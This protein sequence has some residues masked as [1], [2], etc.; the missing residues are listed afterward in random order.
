MKVHHSWY[1]GI[2]TNIRFASH[3][4]CSASDEGWRVAMLLH[5]VKCEPTL[6]REYCVLLGSRAWA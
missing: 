2:D 5:G 1:G 3:V 4:S 6:S